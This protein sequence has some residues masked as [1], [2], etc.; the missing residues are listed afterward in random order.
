MIIGAQLCNTIFVS[1]TSFI[2][3]SL[4]EETQ[5]EGAI[6]W[7]EKGIKLPPD[8]LTWS[9]RYPHKAAHGCVQVWTRMQLCS[10]LYIYLI[11]NA[12]YRTLLLRKSRSSHVEL[13]LCSCLWLTSSTSRFLM[14]PA[15]SKNWIYQNSQDLGCWMPVC[16]KNC[17]C[18]MSFLAICYALLC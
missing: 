15:K 13:Y 5:R 1:S 17:T 11:K 3:P 10:E 7:D 18:T 8:S 16:S 9:L 4:R 6:D 14:F 2:P 12:P